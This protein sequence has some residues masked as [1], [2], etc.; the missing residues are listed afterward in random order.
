MTNDSLANLQFDVRGLDAEPAVNALIEHAASIGASDLFFTSHE[1]HLMVQARHHGLLRNLTHVADELA[2]RCVGHVKAAAGLNVAER[3]RPQDGRWV[4]TRPNG[5]TVDLRIGI[6]PTNF[7][8]DVAMRLLEREAHLLDLEQLGLSRRDH[9][10]LLGMLA[11]PSG[12]ILVTGATG[13]G[14]TTTL[15]ACVN[16]LNNGER[17]I[18]TIEDPIEYSIGGIRQSQVNSR[19][20]LGFAEL[21]RGV[22]RQAPDV[23]MVGEIRDPETAATA[24]LAANSGHLVLA[25]LHA[26]SA[27]GAVQSMY[28]LGVHPHFLS[29]SLLGVITQRLVRTLC[30]AC[31]Q[32]FDLSDS[33]QTFEEIRQHLNPG[34]GYR[35][36]GPKGCD[37]CRQLGYSGRTGVFEILKL[38]PKLRQMIVDKS[39]A[40][41]L[42]QQALADGLM[43]C[44]LAALLKVARGE[45]SIEEVFRAIPPELL[46]TEA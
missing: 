12:L 26:P 21:L 43:Q 32:Q 6:I 30:P 38:T 23:I 37:A 16:H 44:R 25:T 14:K 8:E 10:V 46:A 19:I 20:D 27:V 17:K 33:P 1:R 35:M 9:N 42:Y 31:R 4:F 22:L 18:N 15:Y 34:E 40:A 45:T 3:R 5:N 36:F 7:G 2:K 13:S 24:V 39:P 28:N 41:T 29:G 11:N